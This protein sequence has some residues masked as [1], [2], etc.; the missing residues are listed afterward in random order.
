MYGKFVSIDDIDT[1]KLVVR[2]SD[3]LKRPAYVRATYTMNYIYPDGME[4]R[5]VLYFE[6]STLGKKNP[7]INDALCISDIR[8]DRAITTIY[9]K[10][11]ELMRIEM[12]IASESVD[13]RMG[14]SCTSTRTSTRTRTHT[15]TPSHYVRIGRYT[16]NRSLVVLGMRR[17]GY[18]NRYYRSIQHMMTDPLISE[19]KKMSH[20][21]HL[22]GT[23]SIT[24]SCGV[25]TD[26]SV[27]DRPYIR[28]VINYLE[29]S[30]NRSRVVSEIQFD[31]N[32]LVPVSMEI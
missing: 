10:Y 6:K 16:S 28:P 26:Q 4:D 14:E 2:R 13:N 17:E 22:V 15:R 20:R 12:K 8:F 29:V 3:T 21:F 5:L 31:A 18:D 23:G 24:F 27:G 30:L 32:N 11:M 19:S 9:Q 7:L 25:Y 1:S